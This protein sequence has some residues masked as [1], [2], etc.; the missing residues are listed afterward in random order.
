MCRKSL[1]LSMLLVFATGL[2]RAE[3]TSQAANAGTTVSTGTAPVAQSSLDSTRSAIGSLIDKAS[4]YLGIKY[5]FGGNGPE[6]GGFDCSGLVRKVFGDALGLSLPRTA[7]EMA[8]IGDTVGK[9]DL[10][11]GD[12]V[13]FKTMRNTF[14]HVGIYLGDNRFLHAPSTGGRVR[15]DDMRDSYWTRAFRGARRL[16]PEANAA[17]LPPLTKPALPSAPSISASEPVASN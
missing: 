14:S 6:N 2:A 5:R 8:R 4:S 17:V 7:Q 16:V 11:P 12:L 13:F 10:K 9:N 15:V 3:D 1:L